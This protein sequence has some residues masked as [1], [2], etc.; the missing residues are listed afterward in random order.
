MENSRLYPFASK[1]YV[2]YSVRGMC[3]SSCHLAAEAGT[4]MLKLGGNAFDAAIAAAACLVV[5]E[6]QTNGAGSDAFAIFCKKDGKIQ[7]IN[8]SGA[9]G[10]G[11]SLQKMI[12][13]GFSE[14]P[15]YG[16]KAVSVP[17]APAA[18]AKIVKDHG[19]LTLEQVMEPAIRYAREGH[20]LNI[21]TADAIEKFSGKL[22]ENTDCGEQ[23]QEWFKT[24]MPNGELPH[25]GEIFKNEPLAK[26]LETIAKTGAADY[27]NGEIAEK[28]AEFTQKHG[29]FIHKSDMAAHEAQYVTPLSAHYHGY[30]IWELPP[31]GQ[32]IVALM[33]LNILNGFEPATFG[34]ARDVHRQIE[35]VK[36]AFGDGLKYIA[37]PKAMSVTP[38]EMLSA[39]YAA[40]RRALIGETAL[41]PFP[42]DPK[43]PGTVYL[44]AA[45][46]EGNMISYIQ[47]NYAGFGSGA[48]VPGTGIALQNRAKAFSLDPNHANCAEAGK[49]PYHTIIPA[50]LTKDGKPIGPFGVMG[51]FM[52]PQAHVQ[53]MA[54]YIDCGL[55]M[56]ACLD[57][58]R[59]Q[60][61]KGR[62][63]SVE[64]AFPAHIFEELAMRGHKIAYDGNT[65]M[66]GKGQMIFKTKD[67]S[68]MGATEPRGE[69]ECAAW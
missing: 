11:F 65:G 64:A 12:D 17:G 52:Q 2:K 1:R 66:Y 10:S 59:W 13:D 16:V 38:E 37:D 33:A 39:E 32:G 56:Q 8:S 47:S 48:L 69:G 68:L 58:P 44:C 4:D 42:G 51:G 23:Y 29:G 54:N 20:A 63:I 6:P 57:A 36:L 34:C 19:R 55:N 62:D 30:D 27:Y 26:T 25:A 40:S 50:F 22:H 61:T 53:V 28:I 45:D 15:H 18:W 3:A 49:K 9:M 46:G 14:M 43:K 21:I 41:E 7:G 24:F 67:G 5:M 35:A 60:W 31:N